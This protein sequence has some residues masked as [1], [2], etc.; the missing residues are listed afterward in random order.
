MFPD[1][2]HILR[3]DICRFP[4]S[5]RHHI[6]EYLEGSDST[7]PSDRSWNKDLNKNKRGSERESFPGIINF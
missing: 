5:S 7:I 4:H 2:D 6:K 3:A 1:T